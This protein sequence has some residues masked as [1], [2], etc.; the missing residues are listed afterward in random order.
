MFLR[1]V[2]LF[3]LTMAIVGT[4]YGSEE[5][6]RKLSDIGVHNLDVGLLK[7]ITANVQR[8]EALA[9]LRDKLG[10][11]MCF[12]KKCRIGVVCYGHMSRGTE[13]ETRARKNELKKLFS[14]DPIVTG[15]GFNPPIDG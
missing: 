2:S 11:Q 9:F 13:K 7:T 1:S 15:A 14:T 12:S 8:K 10:G 3:T 4:A 5:M 6:Q